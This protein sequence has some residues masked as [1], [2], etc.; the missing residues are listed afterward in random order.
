MTWN[1]WTRDAHIYAMVYIAFGARRARN[2][3]AEPESPIERQFLCTLLIAMEIADARI[4]MQSSDSVADFLRDSRTEPKTYF[5]WPQAPLGEYRAD[6]LIAREGKCVAIECDG[7]DYHDRTT[8]QVNRDK[9]R[10][11]DFARQGVPVLRF[12]GS[13]IYNS[14]LESVLEVMAFLKN[15]NLNDSELTL[16]EVR[17]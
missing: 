5:I 2:K 4:V 7:R 8:E 10:D 16:E 13:E 9:A 6:F 17:E 1:P 12:S 3:I 15:V 11:R 14:C